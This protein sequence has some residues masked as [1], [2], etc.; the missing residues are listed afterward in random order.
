[1]QTD[2]QYKLRVRLRHRLYVAIRNKTKTGSAVRDLGCSI[3]F[4]K[5]Y[6]EKKFQPGMSWENWEL[7]GWHIDHI[8]PL[9]SFD[10]TDRTQLLD[11]VNYKN[12]QPLWSKAN[13][14]KGD[15]I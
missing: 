10:S 9:S 1:M 7:H 5:N 13:W 4:L 11:A 2:L 14:K 3:E 6:L 8:K 15:S 12:L